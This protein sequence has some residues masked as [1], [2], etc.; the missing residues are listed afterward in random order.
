MK[1]LLPGSLNE[2]K[3]CE[4]EQPAVNFRQGAGCLK[5]FCRNLNIFRGDNLSPRNGQLHP[6]NPV[7][8]PFF[9][10]SLGQRC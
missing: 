4:G 2:K 6:V 5:D 3:R 7:F 1:C 9:F 8:E 10:V